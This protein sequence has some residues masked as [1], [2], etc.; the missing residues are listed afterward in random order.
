LTDKV[1]KQ[2]AHYSKGMEKAHCGICKHFKAPDQCEVVAGDVK[3]DMW[4]DFFKAKRKKRRR[5]DR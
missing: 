4:C 1:S 2:Q 3:P 5:I